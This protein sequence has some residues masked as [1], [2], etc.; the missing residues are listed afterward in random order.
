MIP[1]IDHFILRLTTYRRGWTKLSTKPN[2]TPSLNL[3]RC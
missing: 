2:A 3:G 1:D